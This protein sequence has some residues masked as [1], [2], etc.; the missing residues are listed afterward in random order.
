MS[1][2]WIY[3]ERG[4]IKNIYKL[5]TNKNMFEEPIATSKIK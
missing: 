1:D 4:V 3:Y 5:L 2:E